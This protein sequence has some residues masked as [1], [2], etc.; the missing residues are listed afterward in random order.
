MGRVITTVDAVNAAGTLAAYPES[1]KQVA[2]ADLIVLTKRDLAPADTA[3]STVRRV[4]AI[5]PAAPLLHADNDEGLA[6]LLGE[7]PDVKRGAAVEEWI[8]DETG[9]A[10]SLDTPREA[11]GHADG[12]H[13]FALTFDRPLEWTAFGLWLTMLLHRHGAAVLRIKGILNVAGQA[14]PVAVHGVQHLVHAPTHMRAWPD[15]DPAAIERSLAVF[16]Q[17]DQ[18]VATA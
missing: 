2:V 10:L 9:L 5:N 17:L 13:A 14:A 7:R 6:A 15:L 18:A 4:R 11:G 3:R 12:I 16:C 1:V 8:A